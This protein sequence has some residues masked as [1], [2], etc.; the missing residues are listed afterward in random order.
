MLHLKCTMFWIFYYFVRI[1]YEFCTNF[2]RYFEFCTFC[3]IKVFLIHSRYKN[4]TLFIDKHKKIIIPYCVINTNDITVINSNA[5]YVNQLIEFETVL[6]EFKCRK[7]RFFSDQI[8][9][10]I[11]SIYLHFLLLLKK[12]RL[13]VNVKFRG[14]A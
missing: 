1:L 7:T 6:C 14:L 10:S 8:E 3:M 2:V 11:S 12:R 13:K 9:I 5:I 4:N